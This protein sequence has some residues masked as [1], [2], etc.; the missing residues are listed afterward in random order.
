MQKSNKKILTWMHPGG[1]TRTK[2]LSINNKNV[3]LPEHFLGF[4]PKI[5]LTIFG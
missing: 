5:C 3:I 4:L 1:L 2:L